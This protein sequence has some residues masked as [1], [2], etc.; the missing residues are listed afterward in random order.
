MKTT[1]AGVD[2]PNPFFNASGVNCT[3]KEELDAL[4]KSGIGGVWT[5]TTTLAPRVGNPHPRVFTIGDPLLSGNSVGLANNGISDMLEIIEDTHLDGSVQPYVLSIG[6]PDTNDI[7]SM[8]D[9]AKDVPGVAAIE[10]NPSC[11]NLEGKSMLAFDFEEFESVLLEVKNTGVTVPIGLKLPYYQ[12]INHFKQV[13][14]II[15]KTDGLVRFITCI[16]GMPGLVLDDK[17][18]ARTVANYGIT[19]LGGDILLPFALGNISTFYRLF[20]E[21]NVK[22]DIIGCGGVNTAMDAFRMIWVG[23]KGVQLGTRLLIEIQ[24]N[25]TDNLNRFWT[26]TIADLRMFMRQHGNFTSIEE[27]CGAY[28]H[29]KDM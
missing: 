16:N 13:V 12:D 21:N 2:F 25:G 18:N 10:I 26:S 27:M 1:I 3:T 5:K 22:C 6:G 19:G 17:Y 24:R 15:K 23:A 28:Y 11:P 14:N 4:R 20:Q 9:I 8:I 29:R 7:V